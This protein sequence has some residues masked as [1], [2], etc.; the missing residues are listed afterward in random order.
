MIAKYQ[1]F[2]VQ[3]QKMLNA[4]RSFQPSNDKWVGT[5][6]Y[7]VA[8]LN[9]VILRLIN[10][11]LELDAKKNDLESCQASIMIFFKYVERYYQSPYYMKWY[12]H[13]IIHFIGKL[14]IP[15]VKKLLNSLA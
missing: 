1:D 2:V 9:T 3:N 14:K 8:R 10:T 13:A 4:V 12:Y 6:D 15:R 7:A 11:P 5:L